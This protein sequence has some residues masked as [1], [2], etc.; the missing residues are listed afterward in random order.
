MTE[1]D[2]ILIARAIYYAGVLRDSELLPS[3]GSDT[4][5]ICEGVSAEEHAELRIEANVVYAAIARRKKSKV[6]S[7]LKA[8][9]ALIESD[10]V[11]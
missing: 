7:D 2:D 3:Y 1:S 8:R 6:L 9:V 5:I 4:T 11:F 10:V